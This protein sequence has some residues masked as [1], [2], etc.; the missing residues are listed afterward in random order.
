M[1]KNIGR[2]LAMLWTKMKKFISHNLYFCEFNPLCNTCKSFIVF[3]YYL[4]LLKFLEYLLYHKDKYIA[5]SRVFSN[6][7]RQILTRELFCLKK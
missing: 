2:L 5:E 4:L 1:C 3:C 6:L 7:N